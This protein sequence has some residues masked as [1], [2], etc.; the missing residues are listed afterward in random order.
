MLKSIRYFAVR[1]F[2]S[3][4]RRIACIFFI[5][6]TAFGLPDKPKDNPPSLPLSRNTPRVYAMSAHVNN[7]THSIGWPLLPQTN[8]SEVDLPTI[9]FVNENGAGIPFEVEPL[10][11]NE[12]Q[13]RLTTGSKS[14]AIRF[15]ALAYSSELDE[16]KAVEISWPETWSEDL[17]LYLQPSRFIES[18]DAIFKKA[19]EDN[20]D[21]TSVPIHIAA[22]VLIRY[23]LQNIQSSGRYAHIAN[24]VTTG[25]DVK[26]A[27]YTVK[28][29]KGSAV[30]LVCVCIAT[31][32]NAGIPARPVVGITNAD[33]VG[34]RSIEPQFIVWGEYA[35]PGAGWVPFSPERMRGTVDGLSRT[36]PWQG[37]GTLPWLNRRLPI[38]WNFDCFDSDR[39]TTTL[40]VEMIFT[41]SPD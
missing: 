12:D 20:G 8:W 35:L 38:A 37:L 30:D 4:S 39:S 32:R 33:T 31:L 26:G 6:A 7:K 29:E 16:A 40:N 11:T 27:R 24:N 15:T 17:Q 9:G 25:L 23:C 18:N 22:K 1:R 13:W 21:P 3:W 34:T 14:Y 10:K 2:P 41:S 36:E 5:T 28:N 19:V